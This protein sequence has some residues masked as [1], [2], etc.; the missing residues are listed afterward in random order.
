[1]KEWKRYVTGLLLIPVVMSAVYLLPERIFVWLM[2]I[3]A[4]LAY[5]EF[6]S[7]FNLKKDILFAFSSVLM[8]LMIDSINGLGAIRSIGDITINDFYT[9]LPL[10]RRF[11]LTAT[12]AVVLIPVLSLIGK[13]SVDM[14]LKKMLL[15]LSGFFYLGLTFGLFSA[16]RHQTDGH[17]WLAFA[18]V[19]PWICDT[20]AYYGGR[21]FGKRKFAPVISPNKTWEGAVSG[22]L[23]SVITGAVFAF[24][25][26]KYESAWYVITVSLFIGIFGQ[27]GDLVESLI[28]RNA[29]VKDS[30]KLFPGHGGILDRC[31]SLLF[32]VAII[33]I[34]FL[35]RS[36]AL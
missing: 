36:Y 25:L 11:F 3:F 7:I 30:G 12:G 19:V 5:L 18:F 10:L 14:K 13:D 16:I 23:F 24:T 9:M 22:T 31:D 6:I 26:L 17:H 2:M 20:G 32:S 4:Y 29:G 35:I 28:K 33:F 27:A 21:F 8:L 15:Y 34:G 1:M